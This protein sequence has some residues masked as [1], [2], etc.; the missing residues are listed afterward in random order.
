MKTTFHRDLKM[1][2]AK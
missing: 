1:G 2:N